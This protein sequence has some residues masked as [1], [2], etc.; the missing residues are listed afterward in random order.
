[1]DIYIY[2]W[3]FIYI[4]KMKGSNFISNSMWLYTEAK[5]VNTEAIVYKAVA[6]DWLII[7][8]N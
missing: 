6:S 8:V 2:Q 4:V 3:I 1:M 7:G 5:I